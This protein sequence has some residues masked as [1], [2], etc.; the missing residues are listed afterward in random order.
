MPAARSLRAYGT[1]AFTA[2]GAAFALLALLAAADGRFSTM[3]VWLVVAFVVDG[4]DG[5]MARRYDVTEHAPIID[6]ALLDLVIDYLTYVFVPVFALLSAG[7]LSGRLGALAAF[8]V[9]FASALYFA[10]TRMKT[11]DKSFSGFP[12]AWNMV[13]LVIFA[14]RPDPRAVL[15]IVLVLTVAM[16]VPVR[17]VHPVRTG[18]WWQLSLPV[19]IA[20]TV[21]AGWAAWVDFTQPEWASV[22]L[23]ATSVYLGTV[24]ALQQ[25]L[26]REG[27]GPG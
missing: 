2:T 24:G 4:I 20:W 16:F 19:A 14:I 1:H 6:G 8:T 7:L 9:A 12:A 10:D 15:V 21:L 3:F 25:L 11:P 27:V 26:G 13:A 18:R 17:F 22:V 5:P 23:I